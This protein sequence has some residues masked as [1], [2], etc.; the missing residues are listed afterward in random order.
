MPTKSNRCEGI[1]GTNLCSREH[2][3]LVTDIVS[4]EVFF[5]CVDC[6]GRILIEQDIDEA[7]VERLY[8]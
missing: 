5:S 3:F 8:A 6:V 7:T 1:R 2:E 4:G